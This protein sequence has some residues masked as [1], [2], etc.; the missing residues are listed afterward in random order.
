VA[1]RE[2]VVQLH[3]EFAAKLAQI[4][5]EQVDARLAEMQSEMQT[6]LDR[7]EQEATELRQRTADAESAMAEFVSAMG[8]VC[9][10]AAARMT[11]S[12]EEPAVE[13]AQAPEVPAPQ[14]AGPD[15]APPSFSEGKKSGGILKMPL[16]SSLLLTAGMVAA[17]QL[18]F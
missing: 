7:K 18:H 8:Q 16:V 5:G 13:T 4:V 6:Q 9:R 12:S 3:R 15:V 14:P 17:L 1:L 11:T 2:E 10:D